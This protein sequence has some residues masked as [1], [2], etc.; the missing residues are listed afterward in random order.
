MKAIVTIKYYD[1]NNKYQSGIFVVENEFEKFLSNKVVSLKN[2][3]CNIMSIDV[4]TDFE[5]VKN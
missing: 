3:G 4:E 5:I 1:E 2:K